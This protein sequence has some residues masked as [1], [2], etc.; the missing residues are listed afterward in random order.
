M[1][2]Y[3]KQVQAKY[4]DR[5]KHECNVEY[6]LIQRYYDTVV[7]RIKETYTI[8]KLLAVGGTGIVHVG[9]HNRFPQQVVLKFNRPIPGAAMVEHEANVLPT[10]NHPNIIRIL[11]RGEFDEL[12]P[13]LTYVVEPFIA[14]SRPFFALAPAGDDEAERRLKDTWLYIKLEQLKSS[15]PH[16]LP[17]LGSD[18]VDQT[19]GLASSLLRDLAG[20]FT[21]WVS[22]L[23]HLHSK[24]DTAQNGYVYLDVKP[25]NVL[26][27]QH[28]HLMSIDYGSVEH[29][30]LEDDSPIDVFV[31]DLY[32][33]PELLKRKKDR[34]SANRVRSGLK[35]SELT[36]AFDFFSLG[37]SMLQILNEVALTRPHVIPQIPLYRSLHFL[38][39]RLLDGRN[40]NRKDDDHYPYA[41]QIFP[42]LKESDYSQLGYTDL[43][44]V[45]WDLE[46]EQGRWNLEKE[47]PELAGYSKDIVRLVPG[48]NT[49]LTPR[50]GRV[51]EHPLVA[52]LKCVTQ[53]GLVSL[54]Y[55]TADHSRYD[56]ALGSYTYTTYYI[57]TLF[58]DLGNPIFRNLVGT[59]DLNGLL[60]AAL[61]HDLGQY[62]LAH[63]LEEVHP[64]IF[65]HGRITELLLDDTTVDGQGR[66]LLQIIEDPQNGW[67]VRG[68]DLRRILRA[69]SKNLLPSQGDVDK[70][71][72]TAREVSFKTEVLA[73]IV[74]GPVDADK[75]DYIIRDSAR[76]EL[77]YG[78][79][80]DIERLLRVLTLAILPD[81]ASS[82][83]R[84]TLGVY[85][86]GLASAHAFG[87]ARYLLFSTVYW[88]HTSRITKAMLQYATVMGLPEEVFLPTTVGSE[89]ATVVSLRE[90]LLHFVKLLIPPFELE[91]DPYFDP[92]PG[93]ALDIGAEPPQDIFATLTEPADVRR[94]GTGSDLLDGWYPGVAWTDWLMLR[95]IG[96]LP[97]ASAESRNLVHGLQVRKLYKR[98]A[99]LA[100]G[101]PHRVLI[102]ALDG[103][104]W[105]EKLGVCRKLHKRIYTK[106]SQEWAYVNTNTPLDKPGFEKLCQEHLLVLIDIPNPA[107][108]VGYDRPLGV[109]PELK[110]KSY[111]QHTR[112]AV[113]DEP[114]RN[115][116]ISSM[117]GIGPVRILCH[118]EIR[119]VLG[120]IYAPI[121]GVPPRPGHRGVE[122]ELVSHLEEILRS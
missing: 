25:E 121:E 39:T 21:Q 111:Y 31:T 109:V 48:F 49:V 118:P 24:H 113:E 17:L 68:D 102:D 10:V 69:H 112:Q 93:P 56:H 16:V 14:G 85:D 42:G 79:Q 103:L 5:R 92:R 74:D 53:L 87:Q 97:S 11:D 65:K 106:L 63:D 23:H 47:I 104:S 9:H 66:T 4:G 8:D 98:I 81:D 77:P 108:K 75:A 70:Q 67:G 64:G 91:K 46:K 13:K 115:I 101:G 54:V 32:A 110:E 26:V 20:L 57:K 19:I 61:L 80:L 84:V 34:P 30:D 83:R 99:T 62:P 38:A 76:C 55:P 78:R 58:N 120:S 119:T 96:K 3:A 6:P 88:H 82:L 114:W 44:D 52:R 116:M 122:A 60:L 51:I 95:W 45:L 18:H 1:E 41:S 59:E 40:S 2:D 90:R 89:S 94:E 86:K 29:L 22:L 73:S 43:V 7:Q 72:Q 15:M 35:R 71:K 28:N 33:H 100:R 12:D 117:S 50:L 36:P 37:A 107:K 105:L 27:D